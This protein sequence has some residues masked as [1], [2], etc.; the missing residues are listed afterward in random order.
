MVFT[1][2]TRTSG[3]RLSGL[4]VLAVITTLV[5]TFARSPEGNAAPARE[6]V[7]RTSAGEP[8]STADGAEAD[9]ADGKPRLA[10]PG[11]TRRVTY[12]GLRLDVPASWKVHD[13]AAKPSTCV[14]F[15]RPAVYLGTPGA[16]QDCP[17]RAFGRTE[18]LL[19]QPA[20]ARNA[21][22]LPAAGRSPATL[23]V[24]RSPSV[25]AA[26]G[27]GQEASFGW[28]GTGLVV[29]A[30]YADRPELVDAIIERATYTGPKRATPTN[31]PQGLSDRPSLPG[32]SATTRLRGKGF[33]TCSAPSARTMRAW[34][35]SPYR[36]VGIYIG[37]VNR[38]C[39]DGNLSASWVRS[40]AKDG[41][42]TIPIYVGRQAPCA[43]Q[44]DLG[45]IRRTNVVKQGRDAAVDAIKRAQGFGLP[46]GSAIYYDM[47]GYDTSDSGC[48]KVVLTFLSA[49]TQRLHDSGYLSGVYSSA[50]SGIRDLSK[51][52][53]S[54]TYVR[55]DA[56]WFA[57]WDGKA[58]V[59]GERY[60]PGV[61]WNNHQRIKQY[62]GPH[63][64]TWGGRRIEIDSN[65]V[66]AL[67]GSATYTYSVRA[68]AALRARS[69]P[70]T[71]YPVVRS[72]PA[73][74]RLH[75]VCQT[76]GG[77]V[78]STPVWDKLAD[79]G[80]VSD[81]YVS[82]PSKKGYSAPIPQ[83]RYPFTVWTDALTVRSGPGTSYSVIGQIPYG[84]M[85]YIVCQRVG[86]KAGDSSVWDKL[87]NGGWV[88]DWYTMTG[89]RPGF[90]KPIPRCP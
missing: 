16:D 4:A 67:I 77:R 19:V 32:G 28:A 81:N 33:D 48:S 75:V 3:R 90:T 59:W 8:A 29:T 36:A 74:A 71:G 86:P 27:A 89:G 57:R 46:A 24:G 84:G 5:A 42:R 73:G 45:P 85:A 7:V 14:R 35:A 21:V 61:Q 9:Q 70:G 60:A 82:T 65:R 53:V 88:A 26:G 15:D 64:E 63:T 87:D 78:A 62:R 13:L 80:Y 49:W 20:T 56:I 2:L 52:Y 17:A 58:T 6:P 69:G 31:S 66:D 55:P 39:P 40:I 50:S 47:E 25:A 54:N 1:P 44:R 76:T 43:F 34:L 38:A 23:T 37:G 12:R 51:V 41:W 18:A 83:C 22:R 79:G 68:N 30:A 10:A 11:A 72:W